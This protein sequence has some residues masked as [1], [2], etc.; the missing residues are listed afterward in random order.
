MVISFSRFHIPIHF[1]FPI[2]TKKNTLKSL[3]SFPHPSSSSF[4]REVV[5]SGICH[6]GHQPC[7]HITRSPRFRWS[8]PCRREEGRF[9]A[10]G[11]FTLQREDLCARWVIPSFPSLPFVFPILESSILCLFFLFSSGFL[12]IFF[13]HLPFP[14]RFI[15]LFFLV[16]PSSCCPFRNV[17]ASV[18]GITA[19]A[20]I[21]I[22]YARL[23]A[24]RYSITYQEPI[25]VEQLVQKICDLK[26][27]Y[28]QYGGG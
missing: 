5:P 11:A 27:G 17:A 24:Q 20:N 15:S 21:L 1:P 7:G 18:A 16:L 9:Q 8:R 4:S 23:S 13:V 19:D 12:F 26:Q 10:P 22:N 14:L 25:P 6:G 3:R 28:T 2:A